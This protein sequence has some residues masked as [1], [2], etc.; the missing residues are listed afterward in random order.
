MNI[1]LYLCQS[2]E[3]PVYELIFERGVNLK[4]NACNKISAMNNRNY[5]SGFC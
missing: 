3:N 2:I 1:F 4:W 5:C